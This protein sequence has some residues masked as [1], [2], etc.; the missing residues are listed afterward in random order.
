D[1]TIDCIVTDHAPHTV[2]EKGREF[3]SAPFGIVGL[4]TAL[5]LAAEA[6]VASGIWDWPELIRRMT[7]APATLL[8]L[9]GGSLAA[10]RIADITIIDPGATWRVTAGSLCSKSTNTPFDGREVVGRPIA[11]ILGG[12]L[13]YHMFGEADRFS[14]ITT[15][16]HQPPALSGQHLGNDT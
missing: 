16:S 7:S 3:A 6:M 1:G 5:A 12:R 15:E 10:K 14:P 9:S 8:G 2:E 4:E 11:T 13:T